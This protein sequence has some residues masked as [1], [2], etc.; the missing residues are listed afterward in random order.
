MNNATHSAGLTFMLA[1]HEGIAKSV[2]DRERSAA[3]N[4][5]LMSAVRLKMGF[6]PDDMPRL[7]A[8]GMRTCVGVFRPADERFYAQGC[9]SGGTYARMWEKAA[10][11]KPFK[12]A[13]AGAAG[14]IK[15]DSR[16]AT[17]L[18][19]LLE[20]D[21]SDD[22][23]P[24]HEG[25]QVWWVTSVNWANDTINLSRYRLRPDSRYPFTKNDPPAKRLTL[26][27][28]EWESRMAEVSAT[29]GNG[30]KAA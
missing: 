21:D 4:E 5:L 27:R 14:D 25:R 15:Q 10:G 12:A 24:R 13:L 1:A 16:V 3:L 20:G 18:A 26:S 2:G 29:M 8:L 11:V 28:C 30:S 7:A 9:I 19:V 6:S 22:L 17:G 23:L